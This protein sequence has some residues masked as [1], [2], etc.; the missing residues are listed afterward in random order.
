MIL[1][2]VAVIGAFILEGGHINGLVSLTAAIIVFVGT[3]CAV[4]ASF[5]LESIKKTPKMMKIAFGNKKNDLPKLIYYFKDVSTKTRRNGLLS[6][7]SEISGN[8][9]VD[10][11]I[12]KGLQMVVDGL[13]PQSVKSTLELQMEMMSERHH[14]GA[15]IFGASG[16]LSPTLGII[17][18]V[19]GLIHV[20]GNLGGDSSNLGEVIAPAFICTFYGL[21]YANLFAIPIAA[22]LKALDADEVKEKMLIIEAVTLIQEG[23]NPNVIGEKLKSFLDGKQLREYE[24]LDK[25]AEV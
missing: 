12:K 14:S 22:K 21:A 17:G 19:L 4:F 7:E 25:G 18:T 16:G 20:L 10:P 13:E 8:A 1:S 15:E 23:V 9:E 24:Q 11:Y 6:L 2:I 5:P 3:A